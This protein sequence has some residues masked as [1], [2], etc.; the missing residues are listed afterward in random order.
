[1]TPTRSLVVCLFAACMIPA[2]AAAE[3]ERQQASTPAASRPSI[4]VQGQ[5]VFPES[6]TS[7]SDGAVIFGSLASGTLYR[8]LPGET[9]ATPWQRLDNTDQ[10]IYGVLNDPERQTLWGCVVDRKG[11]EAHSE[12]KPSP[13]RKGHPRPATPCPPAVPA[14]TSPWRWMERCS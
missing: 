9:T 3:V 4:S 13:C 8:V 12:L 1:M 2:L 5:R 7:T 10:S 14:T 11:N 6:L